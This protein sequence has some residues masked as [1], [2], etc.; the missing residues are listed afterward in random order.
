[1]TVTRRRRPAPRA[2]A[3]QRLD[4]DFSRARRARG[5]G[6]GWILEALEGD[7][8]YFHRRMFGC[9]AAYL[10][11]LLCLVTAENGEPWNGLLVCTSQDRHPA[12][13]T[14]WPQLAPHAVLGKWLYLSQD[15]ADFEP[16]ARALTVRVL[17]RDPRIGVEPKPRKRKKKSR[18]ARGKR[19]TR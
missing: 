6:L 1:M 11:G 14:D 7:P 19:P 10:G 2:S 15:D 18:A 3:A 16:V 9:D 13:R 8:V 5:S 17:A 12:L 4:E